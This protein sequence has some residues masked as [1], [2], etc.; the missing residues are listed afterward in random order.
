MPALKSSMY[1]RTPKTGLPLLGLPWQKVLE[2]KCGDG[3]VVPFVSG[4]YMRMSV[5][6]DM[7]ID[8]PRLDWYV[9][10]HLYLIRTPLQFRTV[11][12]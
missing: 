8:T 4:M 11:A 9:V 10:L 1:S 6:D 7:Y 5:D 2:P 12:P 3:A